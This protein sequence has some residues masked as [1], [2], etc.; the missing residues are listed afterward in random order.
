MVCNGSS[1]DVENVKKAICNLYRKNNLRITIE[2]NK[3]TV[4]FLDVTLCLQTET[5]A[6]N[7][8]ENNTPLY[9]HKSSNHP[10]NI[11]KNI[12]L[13]INKRLS[14]IS[15]SKEMFDKSVGPYQEALKR[16]GYSHTLKYEEPVEN[17][18]PKR[19]RSRNVTYFNP[20]YSANT[21]TDVGR[22]FLN[23]VEK[24][25]P[26]G[27][28]LHSTFNKNTTKFSYS[29]MPSIGKMISSHNANI[30]K[31]RAPPLHPNPTQAHPSS[32]WPHH[33]SNM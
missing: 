12:P 16:S 13:G 2:A 31:E 15:S 8:K 14:S 24:H 17:P 33:L 30:M 32:S 21:T 3:K 22:K 4:N 9:V 28:V 10:P 27:H 1:R 19:T 29:C 26:P 7:L 11:L 25:F 18:K 23:L 6:P 20:P 5:F